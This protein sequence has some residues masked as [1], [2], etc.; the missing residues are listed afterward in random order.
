MTEDEKP[1]KGNGNGGQAHA[2]PIGPDEFLTHMQKISDSM[3]MAS[4]AFAANAAGFRR[5]P[6]EQ[7]LRSSRE[8][9]GASGITD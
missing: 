7:P 5:D 6:S 2:H 1:A 4:D 9:A 3:N 8:C